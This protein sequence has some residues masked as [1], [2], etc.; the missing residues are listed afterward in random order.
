MRVKQRLTHHLSSNLILNSFQSAYTAHHSTESML[1][2]VH[3]H[4]IK[5]MAQQKITALCLLDLWL[6]LVPLITLF[7]FLSTLHRFLIFSIRNR[8]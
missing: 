2:S 1:L 3:D 7:L 6:P 4:I 5:A 8:F